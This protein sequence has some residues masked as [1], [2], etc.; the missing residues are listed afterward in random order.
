MPIKSVLREE[1]EY[2]LRMKREYE[3]ALARLPKGSLVKRQIKGRAYYYLV[4]REGGRFRADY[5]GRSVSRSKL[6]RYRQAKELR[7]KYRHA[8]S[9]LKKQVRY[10][11]GV[12][13][14]KEDL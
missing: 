4:Y 1:L 8:I 11:R 13:R 7:A 3:K 5:K 6:E 10:L 9:R 12:L 2:S 14:G